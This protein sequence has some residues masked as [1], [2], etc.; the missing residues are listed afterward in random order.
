MNTKYGGFIFIFDEAKRALALE[1]RTANDSFT[2]VVS[3]PD[4]QPKEVEL[5]LLSFYDQQLNYAALGHR[6][7]KVA[8]KRYRFTFDNMVP[9]GD[10]PFDEI[11]KRLESRLAPHFVRSSTG[12][13]GRVPPKT[14]EQLLEV[15]RQLHPAA[16]EEIDRLEELR[17]NSK[18]MLR[19][20]GY[21]IMAQ[22]KD[23]VGLALDIFN[24]GTP[25]IDRRKLLSQVKADVKNKP[26]PFLKSLKSTY[27]IEDVMIN[28]DSFVFG[29]WDVFE[30]QVLATVMVRRP[31]ETLTIVNANRT[32]IEHT[33]GVDLVYYNHRFHS[34]VMVQYK[35]M[36]EERS[37]NF[38]YRPFN[39]KS[40][41]KEYDLMKKFEADNPEV[42]DYDLEGYRLYAKTF[43]WKLCQSLSYKPTG[44]ELIPGMYLPLD[45]WE[46]LIRSDS[47]KGP[48]GGVGATR[49][50]V[51]RHINNTLFTEL[52]QGGWVGS[53]Y[54]NTDV[55]SQI[56]QECLDG[57]DSLM[58]AAS[59]P[60]TR[61]N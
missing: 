19:Q 11:E 8:Y 60:A 9:L 5:C 7:N 32:D 17:R 36:V 28:N 61:S 33:L 20:E 13:G 3:G 38:I 21:Q 34:F 50:N 26:A 12:F 1:E 4:W 44:T 56:I 52:V 35:R 14:W 55:L 51:N 15:I 31:D 16:A 18:N 42:E 48:Q 30:K 24:R 40:Y 6:G 54:G 59:Q 37:G 58:L 53:R 39:D 49:Y 10:L 47:L 22:E 43:F 45:F 23:A 2:D 41:M 25:D 57:G 46:L 29:D 27:L